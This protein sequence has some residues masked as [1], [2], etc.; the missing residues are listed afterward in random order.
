M[1]SIPVMH[2][3]TDLLRFRTDRAMKTKSISCWLMLFVP[4]AL[5][6]CGGGDTTVVDPTDEQQTTEAGASGTEEDQSGTQGEPSNESV[7]EA[8]GENRPPA[9]PVVLPGDP[10]FLKYVTPKHSVAL[11]LHPKQAFESDLAQELPVEIVVD[12]QQREAGFDVRTIE[13]AVVLLKTPSADALTVGRGDASFDE[14][15]LDDGSDPFAEPEPPQ[16]PAFVLWFATPPDQDEVLRAARA[17]P[18]QDAEV[19]EIA[20]VKC[21]SAYGPSIAFPTD[22]TLVVAPL[23]AMPEFLEPTGGSGPLAERMRS[24]VFSADAVVVADVAAMREVVAVLKRDLGEEIP[25][26]VRPFVELAEHVD[27]VVARADASAANLLRIDVTAKDAESAEQVRL[28]LDNGINS[29]KSLYNFFVHGRIQNGPLPDP[30]A[31]LAVTDALV[32]GITVEVEGADV[33]VNAP[34]PDGLVELATALKPAFDAARKAAVATQSRNN[35][36]MIGI[37]LHVYAEGDANNALIPAPRTENGKP[38]STWR[39]E[40]VEAIKAG[41]SEL[42]VDPNL[43]NERKTRYLLVTGPGTLFPKSDSTLTL[44]Q[45]ETGDRP[46][47]N[48]PIVIEVG[49]D[50]AVVYDQPG[51]FVLDPENPRAAMGDT[52]EDFVNVLMSDGSVQR[53]PPT[54]SDAAVTWFLQ[55][56]PAHPK[57]AE[58]RAEL[59]RQ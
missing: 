55:G 1:A 59:A 40:T 22:K 52:G 41:G 21:Y 39:V 31:A 2:T 48:L 32:N 33:S 15:A 30:E 28:T 29:V 6:G 46:A 57:A 12:Q 45:I 44:R 49:P 7:G 11:V 5:L 50:K 53:I 26:Q 16:E 47:S 34:R 4:L 3:R 13:R 24:Q 42:F 8:E 36:K 54:A 58:F 17:H 19:T 38:V 56:S 9:G 14:E 25:S 20:G 37:G 51:D 43:V 23:A 27:V 10:S 35:L 18:D